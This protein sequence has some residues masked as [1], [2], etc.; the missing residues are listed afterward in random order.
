MVWID[1]RGRQL[2]RTELVPLVFAESRSGRGY[3]PTRMS[4]SACMCSG[5]R[6]RC[7]RSIALATLSYSGCAGFRRAS[8]PKP[9]RSPLVR[10]SM[11][12]EPPAPP[13]C[14]SRP[15]SGECLPPEQRR[16]PSVVRQ[17][18][19]HPGPWR[20]PRT[21]IP[22]GQ[23]PFLVIRPGQPVGGNGTTTSRF[24]QVGPVEAVSPARLPYAERRHGEPTDGRAD[25][26]GCRRGGDP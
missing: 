15:H 22:T 14:R 9:G 20:S 2:K 11:E 1:P 18:T 13:A 17:S 6:L 25:G 12:P 21:R 26:R 7:Y 8:V 24:N 16:G 3:S 19:D 4:R 10:P 5:P 23:P